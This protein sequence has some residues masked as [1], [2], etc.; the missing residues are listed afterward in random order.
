MY[1]IYSSSEQSAETHACVWRATSSRGCFT[2]NT[3]I[4]ALSNLNCYR[5]SRSSTNTWRNDDSL[6]LY[7][8][9]K[10]FVNILTWIMKNNYSSDNKRNPSQILMQHAPV[11]GPQVFFF[12]LL[13]FNISTIYWA[14]ERRLHNLYLYNRI[15]AFSLSKEKPRATIHPRRK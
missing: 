6:S 4:I 5:I 14:V 3:L 12:L 9:L 8:S 15:A 7:F 2:Y 10:I 1:C 13:H 11:C